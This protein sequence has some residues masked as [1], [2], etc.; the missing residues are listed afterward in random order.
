MERFFHSFKGECIE[1]ASFQTRAQA[2]SCAFEYIECFYNRS[3]RHS[4]L[5][6]MSPLMYEQQMC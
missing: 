6:Y 5:H 4:T 3:R 1:G 2:S